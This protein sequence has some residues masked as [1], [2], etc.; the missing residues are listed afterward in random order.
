MPY[1][2]DTAVFHRLNEQLRALPQELPADPRRLEQVLFTY[3]SAFC[4]LLTL[5]MAIMRICV[6]RQERRR[7]VS[8]FLPVYDAAAQKLADLLNSEIQ[9]GLEGRSANLVEFVYAIRDGQIGL[10][11]VALDDALSESEGAADPED[12]LDTATTVTNSLKEQIEK[13]TKRAWIKSVLHALNEAI[14][15]VRGVV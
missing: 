6:E 13:H 1:N 8:H 12:H 5:V 3:R 7:Y 4:C 15:I 14:S 9:E 10:E 2:V 11:L